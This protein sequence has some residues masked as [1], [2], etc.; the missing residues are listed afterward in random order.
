MAAVFVNDVYDGS[1]GGGAAGVC[2]FY[3][4]DVIADLEE[5]LEG[6][7]SDISISVRLPKL[8]PVHVGGEVVVHRDPK[9]R[10]FDIVKVGKSKSSPEIAGGNRSVFGRIAFGIPDPISAV[11][12][13][14]TFAGMG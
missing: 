8:C 6:E 7:D 9:V 1:D 2:R 10:F 5:I 12:G 3:C 14:F 11:E 13:D 4:D